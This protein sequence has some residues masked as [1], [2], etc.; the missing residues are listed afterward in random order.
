MKIPNNQNK[1][2][3]I[4]LLSI[5]FMLFFLLEDLSHQL[6]NNKETKFKLQIQAV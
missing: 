1:L 6:V 4:M 2:Y 5:F 3:S